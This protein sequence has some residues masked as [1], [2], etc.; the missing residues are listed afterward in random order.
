MARLQWTALAGSIPGRFGLVMPL[1]TLVLIRGPLAEL[2]GRGAWVIPGAFTYCAFAGT[3]LLFNQF[4]LDRHG[5]KALLL[6]PISDEALLRGKIFGF[7]AWQGLQAI[8]LTV[9]LVLTGKHEP[10]ELL[11]GVLLYA[12]LFLVLSTVGQFSS[13]WQPQ[14]MT[15]ATM[16]GAQPPLTVVLLMVGTLGSWSALSLGLLWLIRSSAPG[17]EVPVF[18]GL[19]L[20]LAAASHFV[21]QGQRPVSPREPREAA[22]GARRA[23]TFLV[24]RDDRFPPSRATGRRHTGR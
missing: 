1:I 16:R 18:A 24:R 20:V 10:L 17:W 9:L 14:P 8:L 6:L 3:N 21:L 11:L 19:A 15:R 12:C 23:V 2:T 22:R 5:V 7:A 4:G 13:L